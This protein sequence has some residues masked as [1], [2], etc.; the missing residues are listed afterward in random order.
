MINA[1]KDDVHVITGDTPQSGKATYLRKKRKFVTML[2]MTALIHWGFF[3]G[4]QGV[5]LGNYL[6]KTV[7]KELQNE[8]S[9]IT[10]FSSLSPIPGF[11]TWLIIEINKAL[12]LKGKTEWPLCIH[13]FCHPISLFSWM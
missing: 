6:I 5:D 10:Q 11:K 3:S 2:D 9:G 13:V 8:F 12:N 4:L 7:V 1:K